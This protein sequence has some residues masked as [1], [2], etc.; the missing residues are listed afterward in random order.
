MPMMLSLRKHR[1]A[2]LSGHI[3]EFEPNVPVFVPDPA[4][5]EAMAAGCVPVDPSDIPF[6]EDMDRAKVEFQGDVRR[7][8]V[9]LAIQAIVGAN[10]LKEFDGGGVPRHEAVSTRVGFPVAREEVVATYQ[11]FTAA[12]AEGREFGLHPASANI[13]RVIEADSKAELLELAKEFDVPDKNVSGLTVKDLR[14]LLLVK[15]S[16]RAAL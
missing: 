11:M 6:Y 8:I 16:G 15:F 3:V 2:S 13:L 7:S 10:D 9:Y 4:V 12:R 5:S 1:I 14:K